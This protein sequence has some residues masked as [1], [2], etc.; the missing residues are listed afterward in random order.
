[1][2]LDVAWCGSDAVVVRWPE[3]LLAVGPFGDH[4]SWPLAGDSVVLVTE[5]RRPRGGEGIWTTSL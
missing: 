2:P 1:M 4:A 5:V 3:L